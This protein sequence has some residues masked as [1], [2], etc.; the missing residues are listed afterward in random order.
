MDGSY[1]FSYTLTKSCLS[2]GCCL[3]K[4][5]LKK[6]I[7]TTTEPETLPAPACFILW[8]FQ[9]PPLCSVRVFWIQWEIMPFGPLRAGF[10]PSRRRGWVRAALKTLP[11]GGCLPVGASRSARAWELLPLSAAS[12]AFLITVLLSS[13]FWERHQ[14]H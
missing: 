8:G 12:A 10:W 5:T 4:I 14:H 13:V 1:C 6:P 7:V 3:R 9:G 2:D 11:I